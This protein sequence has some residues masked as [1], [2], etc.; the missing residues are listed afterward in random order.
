F[1][2]YSPS[3][4]VLIPVPVI[5]VPRSSAF[6]CK[7]SH[8][9]AVETLHLE[10]VISSCVTSIDSDLSTSFLEKPSCPYA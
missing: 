10:L 8:L 5:L 4:A 1:H 3:R 7:V 9:V 2:I 6:P